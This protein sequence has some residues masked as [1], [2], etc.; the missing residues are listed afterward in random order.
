[1]RHI[2]RDWVCCLLL[3]ANIASAHERRTIVSSQAPQSH[4]ER[5]LGVGALAHASERKLP[6]HLPSGD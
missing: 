6:R 2:Q 3:A 1:M 4:C 5:S